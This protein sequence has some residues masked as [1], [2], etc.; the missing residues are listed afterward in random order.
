[1]RNLKKSEARPGGRNLF[2]FVPIKQNHSTNPDILISHNY[3]VWRILTASAV[4]LAFYFF[5]FY[6]ASAF[7]FGSI[8]REPV[9]RPQ[10]SRVTLERQDEG[11]VTARDDVLN[12]GP[13]GG[14]CSA[15]KMRHCSDMR[16]INIVHYALTHSGIRRKKKKKLRS[17]LSESWR[18]PEG[19]SEPAGLIHFKSLF[20]F[21][22]IKMME[23]ENSQETKM[24]KKEGR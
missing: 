19:R 12:P 5:S 10:R 6:P 9:E 16:N 18:R 22:G 21:C 24:F 4:F 13:A 7:L 3:E 2:P 8:R 11:W 1:M 17:H 23:K 15:S 14:I 20:F